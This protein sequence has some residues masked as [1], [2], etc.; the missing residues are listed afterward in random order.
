MAYFILTQIGTGDDRKEAGEY[1][2]GD[3]TPKRARALRELMAWSTD[4]YD[5]ERYQF[6]KD[7]KIEG[8]ILHEETNEETKMI[9]YQVAPGLYDPDTFLV[10]AATVIFPTAPI[11]ANRDYVDLEVAR[12]ALTDF[13][14]R[15]NRKI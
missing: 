13:L 8:V 2:L 10:E 11:Q 12:K 15:I 9:S 1:P 14:S 4:Y 6:A 7:Y 3:R 5:A